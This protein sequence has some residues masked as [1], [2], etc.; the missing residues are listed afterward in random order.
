VLFVERVNP[1]PRVEI[2]ETKRFE[3]IVAEANRNFSL[4]ARVA[5]KG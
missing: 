2:I 5:G 1:F 3:V 4:F